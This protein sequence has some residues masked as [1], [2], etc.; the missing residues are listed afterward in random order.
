MAQ[1]QVCCAIAMAGCSWQ[2]TS[3]AVGGRGRLCQALILRDAVLLQLPQHVQK[4]L[5][6]LHLRNALCTAA[7]QG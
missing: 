7:L 3:E 5:R 2:H 1:Q 4:V 6:L